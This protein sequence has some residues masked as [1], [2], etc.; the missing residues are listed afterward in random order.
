MNLIKKYRVYILFFICLLFLL[1]RSTKG[2]CWTD[3]SFYVSTA[4]R[5]YR[6]VV[7]LVGEWYRTQ[8]SSIL[9]LPFYAIYVMLAGTSAGVILYFRIL[10]IILSVAVAI[11]CYRIL[12]KE[13]PDI[14]AAIPALFI[15]C[16]AHLNN[17]TC[18]YYMLSDLF[19]ILG[20]MLI[21]DHKNTLKKSE[22]LIAGFAIAIS[23]FC[24]PV[25]AVGY[26]IIMAAVFFVM[27]LRR[28]AKL[29]ERVCEIIDPLRLRDI[30]VW[31]IIGIAIPAII[32]VVYLLCN[33]DIGTLIESLPY[34]LIDNEHGESLGYFI[35]KPN[36]CL[37]EVYGKG[38]TYASYLLVAIS[39]VLQKYLKKH[40]LREIV[41]FSDA[42]V[43][44]LMAYHSVWFTG[45]ILV[46]FFMFMI[47]V[48]FVS[49]KKNNELFYL[50]SVPA[51]FVA[52]IYCFSSSDFLYV[53]AIGASVATG[54]GVCAV[55]D[56]IRSDRASGD[57]KGQI[58]RRAAAVVMMLICLFSAGQTFVARL[59][60]VYRDAPVSRLTERITTGVAKGLF[61]TDEHL[62]QYYDV[63]ET[64]DEYCVNADGFEIISGSSKGNVL[65]SKILPW[66][67]IASGLDCGYPTTWRTTAY[68][69]D[70]LE[71]Y[72]EINS[73]SRPDII[74]VLDTQYGSYDAAG[75]VEDDHNPNLDEMSDYW[76]DY[77]RDNGFVEKRVKCG[78]VY[79]KIK[80]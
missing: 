10:Y 61:T 62:Q 8:M 49:E 51:V 2:F 42:V 26:V 7:P 5:F 72:Y 39:C 27:L 12:K 22:L 60:N 65:F 73:A 4:D 15:M 23:V 46:A 74:V 24:M 41:I 14:V 3:E 78:K 13:Y 33:A 70:Q 28:F 45:Y 20:L 19:L 80:Q 57:D 59:V 30:T 69:A 6:G 55:Y 9:I 76:K 37:V 77:I 66:G 68:N 63:Y 58:A 44:A 1:W 56:A 32:F 17:A 18:S 36:R 75:D 53:M 38:V 35:R 52:I 34:A 16:Y 79:C 48:F 71:K 43:F 25:F 64:I 54:A 21:Y 47:P 31:T 40:P 67:Y 11:V 29:P 50:M